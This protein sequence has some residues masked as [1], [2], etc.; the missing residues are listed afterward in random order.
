MDVLSTYYAA[1]GNLD[2]N[3]NKQICYNH[4]YNQNENLKKTEEK[5]INLIDNKHS[6]NISYKNNLNVNKAKCAKCLEKFTENCQIV[7][8]EC[9]HIFHSNCFKLRDRNNYECRTCIKC[10]K[11]DNLNETIKSNINYSIISGELG[12]LII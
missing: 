7:K 10:I 11:N 5:E 3:E 8:L 1:R 4:K 9:E 2:V 6:K 12:F